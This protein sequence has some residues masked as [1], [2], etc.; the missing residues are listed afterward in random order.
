MAGVEAAHRGGMYAIAFTSSHPAAEFATA[1]QIVAS[2]RDIDAA[3]LADLLA[4]R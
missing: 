4:S 3:A 2:L 1:D